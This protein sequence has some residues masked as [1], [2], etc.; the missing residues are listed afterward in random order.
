MKILTN[1]EMNKNQILDLVLQSLAIPPVNA[2][3]GQVYYDTKDKRVYFYNNK[4]WVA[5]DSKDAQLTNSQIVKTINEGTEL[6]NINKIKDLTSK[7]NA[8]YLVNIINQGS[9]NIDAKKINSLNEA[10][11]IS[12][13]IEKINKNNTLI[14]IEKIDGLNSKL[15]V[16]NIIQAINTSNKT[17]PIK[18]IS[19]LENTLESKIT[20]EQAQN[21][22]DNALQS[23]KEFTKAE[24]NKLINGASDAYDT[25]KEIEDILKNNDNL[26]ETLE[27]GIK[28]RVN[29]FTKTLNISKFGFLSNNE[30]TVN[31]NLNT[32]DI[33]VSIRENEAPYSL[34]FADVQIKDLNTILVNLTEADKHSYIITILG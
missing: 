14:D 27:E 25:F 24:I 31:H 8:E 4:N 1:L 7:F 5:M 26:K 3:E 34:I 33:F 18:K 16:N 13:L 23:A 30:F 22:A 20:N 32:K 2:K 29:K 19:G 6:I 12:S 15:D 10:I 21:K 17:F 11:D 28:G 9:E